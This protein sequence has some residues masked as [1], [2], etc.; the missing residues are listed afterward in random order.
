M[1]VVL[2][3]DTLSACLYLNCFTINHRNAYYA[4]NIS[5][6]KDVCMKH[7]TQTRPVNV[8]MTQ[9]IKLLQKSLILS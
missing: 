9:N 4:S 5:N 1:Q 6:F 7:N 2:S 3:R 8:I